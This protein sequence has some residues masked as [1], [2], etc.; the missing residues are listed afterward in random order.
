MKL[1][2]FLMYLNMGQ[3]IH[4]LAIIYRV[5]VYFFCYHESLNYSPGKSFWY[6]L[7]LYHGLVSHFAVKETQAF[8][9]STTTMRLR[10]VCDR[11]RYATMVEIRHSLATLNSNNLVVYGQKHKVWVLIFFRTSKTFW[12]QNWAD[13]VKF[14]VLHQN[15]IIYSNSIQGMLLSMSSNGLGNKTVISC[16]FV[17]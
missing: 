3:C 9:R 11:R 17:V 12:N 16:L 5:I 14:S 10:F 8:H 15:P 2:T 4:V 6:W 1:Y 7:A 13:W